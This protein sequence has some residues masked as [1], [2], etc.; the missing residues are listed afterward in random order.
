MPAA[1][2]YIN[3]ISEMDDYA[4][5]HTWEGS[6][7]F[8]RGITVEPQSFIE[9]SID[10]KNT[11]AIHQG[12]SYKMT[13]TLGIGN[14]LASLSARDMVEGDMLPFSLGGSYLQFEIGPGGTL[15][16]IARFV[17]TGLDF[18]DGKY[19]SVDEIR[20]RNGDGL[21]LYD[22]GGNGIFVKDGGQV[23]FGNI[24]PGAPIDIAV[25]G[26]GSELL[27]FSTERPWAFSQ[28]GSGA[29]THL[30]LA[31]SSD[32]KIFYIQSYDRNNTVFAAQPHNTAASQR[33]LLCQS[34]GRVGIDIAI[35]TA[36]LYVDQA[37]TTAAIPV[38]TLDQA[39]ID[40]PI[41]K[42][43]GTAESGSADRSL[44]A[45]SDFTTPGAIVAWEM[46]YVQD[47]GNRFT[48]AKYYRPLYAIPTA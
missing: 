7:L 32:E 47:D 31:P 13:M 11:I 12:N 8:K 2:R 41:V 5:G 42:I 10:A 22:D 24:N 15:V 16:E 38:L 43:I 9:Y 19:I 34:G 3:C 44:V 45:A 46:V 48:D 4:G 21:K 27:R 1:T 28:V 37:S 14:G 33:I 36:K 18:T 6:A 17:G 25:T 20:A 30:G 40:Q 39:D 23:G 26:D 29:A 35:P